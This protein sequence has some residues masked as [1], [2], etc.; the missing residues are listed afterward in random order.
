VVLRLTKPSGEDLT[1]LLAN[2][3][4]ADLS[5]P[6]VGATKDS[7]LPAAYRLD[8]YDRQLGSD[9]NIFER[10]VEALRGWRAHTGAGVEVFPD[11]ARV[12]LGATVLLL[13]KTAGFW[14]VAPC[15][16]VYVVDEPHAFGL[17]YGTLPGH[18]EQG[19]VAMTVEQHERDGVVFRIVSFSRT[20]DPL[21]RLGSPVTRRI[22][23]RV[24]GR[25]VQALAADVLAAKL[26]AQA[27]TGE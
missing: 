12:T 19:E 25:Y 9:E 14:A 17:A 22:Q 10:A 24:T 27:A 21:A 5:Y 7:S 26:S 15:R 18:P 23:R 11:G 1:R 2:A 20:V 16:V 6:E 13:I 8:H 3:K 4:A